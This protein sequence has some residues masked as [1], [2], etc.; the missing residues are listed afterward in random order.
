LELEIAPRTPGEDVFSSP[1]LDNPAF[2]Q[3]GELPRRKAGPKQAVLGLPSTSQ[4][5]EMRQFAWERV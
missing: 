5:A 1:E 4:H 3:A 2:E